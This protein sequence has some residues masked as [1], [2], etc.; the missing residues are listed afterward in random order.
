M[1]IL[2]TYCV[3]IHANSYLENIIISLMSRIHLF[4]FDVVVAQWN[5]TIVGPFPTDIRFSPLLRESAALSSATA[6]S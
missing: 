4:G 1:K 2:M 5:A 3:Y 6:F